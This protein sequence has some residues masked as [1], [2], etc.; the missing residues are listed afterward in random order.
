MEGC[1]D[2]QVVSK[3]VIGHLG[4]RDRL[5]WVNTVAAFTLRW[6]GHG[7]MLLRT[8]SEVR[9]YEVFPARRAPRLTCSPT[10]QRAEG[11]QYSPYIRNM[12]VWQPDARLPEW[13]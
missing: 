3:G 13:L 7:D 6:H 11:C 5:L 10:A 8:L 1:P 4:R 2:G 12:A 9:G